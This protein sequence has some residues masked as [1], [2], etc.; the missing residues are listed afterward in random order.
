[1]RRKLKKMKNKIVKILTPNVR[2]MWPYLFVPQ[3]KDKP[4]DEDQWGVRIFWPEK[5]TEIT[6]MVKKAIAEAYDDGVKNLWNGAEV[7]KDINTLYFGNKKYPDSQVLAGQMCLNTSSRRK[8][9]V[10]RYT[11]KDEE[12][13]PLLPEITDPAAIYGGCYCRLS[14]VFKAYDHKG[15]RG[16]GAYVNNVI[17]MRDGDFLGGGRMRVEDEFREEFEGYEDFDVDDDDV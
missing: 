9:Y 12:G 16:V 4:T 6:A 11:G 3:P 10:C 2:I 7:D 15:N 8:P 13:N 1:M 14:I 5:N 17:F